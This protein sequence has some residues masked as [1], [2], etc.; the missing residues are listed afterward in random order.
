MK[1]G[2]K[3]FSTFCPSR[4]PVM[5]SCSMAKLRNCRDGS[6][7]QRDENVSISYLNDT[8]NTNLNRIVRHQESQFPCSPLHRI[9]TPCPSIE[10]VEQQLLKL[11]FV[12]TSVDATLFMPSSK[13]PSSPSN[14]TI[15]CQSNLTRICQHVHCDTSFAHPAD[16]T[17]TI[18]HHCVHTTTSWYMG[19]KRN[20][21]IFMTVKPNE[22]K[23]VTYERRGLGSEWR[24]KIWIRV[25]ERVGDIWL[26]YQEWSAPVSREEASKRSWK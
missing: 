19:T 2:K 24:V 9:P 13:S 8:W 4:G 11:P 3:S 21:R 5:L 22:E 26:N 25:D 14:F 1:M 12:N 6:H 20:C 7:L 10:Q 16:Q 18:L 17:D 23:V 15:P